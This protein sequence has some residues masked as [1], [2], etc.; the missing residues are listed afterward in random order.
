[1]DQANTKKVSFYQKFKPLVV[2]IPAIFAIHYGW[3][4]L[5]KDERIVPK[6][7][8]LTELPVITVSKII[9]CFKIRNLFHLNLFFIIRIGI[10]E[11][12]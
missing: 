2:M 6:S 7:E 1:M 8:Q 5:Q 10:S 11:G 3:F 9:K 12:F 4:L